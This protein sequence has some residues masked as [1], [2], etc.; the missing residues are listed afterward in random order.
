MISEKERDVIISS[1]SREE[2]LNKA[3]DGMNVCNEFDRN[4][5][6]FTTVRSIHEYTAKMREVLQEICIQM[7]SAS[8]ISDSVQD[9]IAREHFENF[10]MEKTNKRT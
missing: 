2:I 9:H 5:M 10:R 3:L 8:P 4:A 1:D 7:T 6:R